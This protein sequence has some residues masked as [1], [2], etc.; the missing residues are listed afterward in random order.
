M[1]RLSVIVELLSIFDIINEQCRSNNSE[2][3]I[4]TVYMKKVKS[5]PL[6]YNVLIKFRK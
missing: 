5:V 3:V 2:A 4:N 6:V 1:L